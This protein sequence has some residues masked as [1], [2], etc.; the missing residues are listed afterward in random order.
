MTTSLHL[1]KNF[2][3]YSIPSGFFKYKNH[4]LKGHI[5]YKRVINEIKESKYIWKSL[6]SD[7]L[8]YVKECADCIKS[9]G[10]KPI[11]S[12][13]KKIEVKGPKER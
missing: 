11:K 13:P 9:K 4:N 10:G 7:A 3:Y 6:H 2:L 5:N 8:N 12:M 1:R